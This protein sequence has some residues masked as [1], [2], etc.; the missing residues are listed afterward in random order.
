MRVGFVTVG[1][2]ARLTGGYLYHA[3]VF[4]LLRERGIV[5]EQRIASGAAQLVQ[6]AQAAAF[7]AA[8]DPLRYDVVVV[9]ALACVVCAPHL[10]TWQAARP[11]IAMVHELP[12]IAAGAASDASAELAL[13]HADLFITVSR[14]GAA[15]LANRGVSPERIRIVSPG[16]DRVEEPGARSQELEAS[17]QQSDVPTFR[18]RGFAVP[19]FAVRSS[20]APLLLCVAQWIPRKGIA[21]LVAAWARRTARDGQLVLIGE[22]D[23]DAEYA[24]QVQAAIAGDASI[25]VLGAVDDA[26]LA[27]AYRAADGFVL[28]SRYE[29]YGMVYAEALDYGLPIIACTV[30]P[31]P[32][33]VGD[34]AIL[35]PANDVGA[36]AAALDVL[37]T[38]PSRRATLAAAAHVRAAALPTWNAT[39]NDFAAALAAAIRSFRAGV[40]V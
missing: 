5:V 2:P 4:A 28:P 24:A 17:V 29:G 30:G 23:A 36:L 27:A 25:Q 7:G 11:L 16:R 38:D 20:P 37:L 40:R 34:A 15:V 13:L 12:S 35:V 19:Q 1:N 8:F 31:V 9:D 33:L 22:T 6:A 18:S 21:T 26:T 39:A 32:E 3:R 14:H 10:A